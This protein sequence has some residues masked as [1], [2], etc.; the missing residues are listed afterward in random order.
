[1]HQTT[2]RTRRMPQS[3]SRVALRTA[4]G[5][6]LQH[7]KI[8]YLTLSIDGI[9]PLLTRAYGLAQPAEC[10]LYARGVNDIY[11]ISTSADKFA[12]RIS[13]SK[14]RS[15]AAIDEELSALEYVGARGAEVSVPIRRVDGGGITTLRAPEGLRRAVLFKWAEGRS[16]QYTNPIEA[17][18]YGRQ[19]ARLH[20]ALEEMRPSIARPRMDAAE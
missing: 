1:M 3:P 11:L 15:R 16:P 12:L 20:L 18:E 4:G 19:L 9:T 17:Q 5:T 2:D 14:W 7:Q 13:H 6:Q 10:V 8:S